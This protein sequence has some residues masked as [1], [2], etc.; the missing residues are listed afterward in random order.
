MPGRVYMLH[1]E[2][3]RSPAGRSLES[4]VY[5]TSNRRSHSFG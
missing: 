3:V 1:N 5:H 2:L 4:W